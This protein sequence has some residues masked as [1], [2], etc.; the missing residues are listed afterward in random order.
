ML[1]VKMPD[2]LK[3]DTILK[4]LDTEMKLRGFSKQTCY[5]EV[6]KLENY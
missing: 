5:N 2:G 6:E 1:D 3:N 4:N